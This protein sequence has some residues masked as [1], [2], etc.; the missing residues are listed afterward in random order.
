MDQL[1]VVPKTITAGDSIDWLI[2]LDDYPAS[3]SWVLTYYLVNSSAQIT[4]AAIASGDDH[5]ITKTAAGTAA[6]SPG[7]YA[8]QGYV[9]KGTDR[10]LVESGLITVLPNFATQTTGYDARNEFRII[11]D[12]I[13]AVQQSKAT[14]DQ[15]AYSVAGRSIS[16]MSPAELTQWYEWADRKASR[17]EAIA[18]GR[19]NSGII[20]VTF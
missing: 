16:R 7:D 3:D 12:A 9:A 15:L 18:K 13:I 8:Y 10:W 11:A 17:L 6:Y 1:T 5:A 19:N 4:L 14:K 20:K 2:T